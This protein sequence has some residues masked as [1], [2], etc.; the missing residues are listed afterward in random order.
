MTVTTIRYA[1]IRKLEV[2]EGLG[3]FLL[4]GSFE[5]DGNDKL[6]DSGPR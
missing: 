3:P 5:V 2:D 6:E 1:E 4:G